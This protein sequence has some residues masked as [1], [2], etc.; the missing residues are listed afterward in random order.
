MIDNNQIINFIKSKF[1]NINY[2]SLAPIIRELLMTSINRNFEV[3]GRYSKNSQFGGGKAKWKPSQRAIRQNGQTLLDSGRLAASIIVTPKF[4]NGNLIISM[5]S[6][7][8]DK[9]GNNYA[10][11]HQFGVKRRGHKMPARPFLVIQNEDIRNIQN[12][13]AKHITKQFK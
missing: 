9:K 11:V 4:E 5:G 3:G 7:V 2:N 13:I 1:D 10:M 6:N 8:K 12:L